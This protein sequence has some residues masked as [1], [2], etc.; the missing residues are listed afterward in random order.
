MPNANAAGKSARKKENTMTIVEVSPRDGFPEICNGLSTEDKIHYINKLSETG[1]KKIECASFTH[2]RLLPEG[3]D[4]EKLVSGIAKKPE[5]TYVGLVPNE[6]GCRRALVTKID[7]LLVLLSAS[8][9]FNRINIG[10]SLR[11]SLNKVLP[12]L[13]DAAARHGRSVRIY[14][15]TA[16]GCP[17]TG[18]VRPEEVAELLL[19]LSYM[20]ASE[21]VLVDSTGMADPKSAKE[22]IRALLE[23]KLDIQLAVHFHNTRGTALANCV[24]AYDEGIRIFDASLGGMSNTPYGVSELDIGYWNVP[25][26]DIVHL[27]EAMGIQTGIDL[28]KL[29]DCVRLAEKM[30]GKPLPGHILRAR[31]ATRITEIPRHLKEPRL[32]D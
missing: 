2:P 28:E 6:I 22:L 14:L 16:F 31:P 32:L 12:T 1:L 5:V 23:L 30:A 10:K 24:A 18:R 15:M 9:T 26:E 13:L 4:A 27:F 19:K 3:Y 20:G 8:D 17:Y 21:V 11:E 25:T 29:L 7:E